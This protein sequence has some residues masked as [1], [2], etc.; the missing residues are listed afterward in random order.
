VTREGSDQGTPREGELLGGKYRITGRIG[1]GG[2]GV[3]LAA[4]EQPLGRTV[5]IKMLLPRYA[6]DGESAARFL[7]EARAAAAITSEHVVRILAVDKQDD[8]T[9]YIVMEHLRGSDLAQRVDAGGPLPI[10]D[11]VEAVLQACEALAEAHALGIVHRDLKPQNLFLSKRADGS[12]LVKILDFGI[13]KA[14]QGDAPDALTKT[15]TVMG[16]PLYM[17]PEQVRSQKEVDRRADVWA[18]GVV[19]F[20]LSTG[21]P[22]YDAPTV[23]A[24]YAMIAADP[25]RRLTELCPEAPAELEQVILRCLEKDPKRR[26]Q[27]VGALARALAPFAPERAKPAV[28][29]IERIVDTGAE[30]SRPEEIAQTAPSQRR[31]EPVRDAASA[32]RERRGPPWP[33]LAALVAGASAGIFAWTRSTKPPP[34]APPDVPVSVVVPSPVAPPP[35]PWAD[36]DASPTASDDASVLGPAASAAGSA[37][38]SAS[39]S[40]RPRASANASARRPDAGVAATLTDAELRESNS[41]AALAEMT[42][43]RHDALQA[44]LMLAGAL[45]R[46]KAAPKEISVLERACRELLED[47]THKSQ[48]ETCLRQVGVY[49]FPSTNAP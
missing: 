33:V 4:E 19:L 49:R 12:P 27:D 29:R 31:P 11:A 36:T 22:I 21:K 14:P 39:T 42:L 1:E 18:L 3:V 17:S 41:R 10:D 23:S 45:G 2:M 47:P 35:E 40:A 5:A 7:R 15:S 32:P 30:T 24:L 6:R 13:S 9:P 38:A 46:R 28:A 44:Y 34:S 25:P 20:E 37:R 43:K 8:G 48:A 26:F 16:S